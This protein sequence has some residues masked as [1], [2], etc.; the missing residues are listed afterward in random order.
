MRIKILAIFLICMLFPAPVLALEN[1]YADV[2]P[3]NAEVS[4]STENEIP[5]LSVTVFNASEH[6]IH[7]FEFSV[8]L[9]SSDAA[10][11]S[12]FR[13]SASDIAL[14]GYGTSSFAWQLS[15]YKN[16]IQCTEFKITKIVFSDGTVWVP[17]EP[18]YAAPYFYA[19][20]QR[21]ADGAYV[22]DATHSLKLVDYSYSSY[23]RA[24]YIWNDTYGWMFFSSALSPTCQVWRD[25]AVIKLVIN[26]NPALYSIQTFHVV[27]MPDAVNIASYATGA[28]ATVTPLA[29]SDII[30]SFD[31]TPSATFSVPYKMAGTPCTLGLWDLSPASSRAWYIWDGAEWTLFSVDRG[32]ICQIWKSGTTY[33]KLEYADSEAVYAIQ[34]QDE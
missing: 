7:A 20:G 6:R 13:S 23:S 8:V 33:I 2:C 21:T 32:P 27:P 31:M 12:T 11:G 26:D 5:F 22:L 1:I 25:H 24:W 28:V 30:P 14:D 19:L 9:L 10:Y 29:F 34:I 4:L 16:L 18:L 17:R 15:N 3:L